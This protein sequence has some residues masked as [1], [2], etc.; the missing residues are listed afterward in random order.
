MCTEEPVS[1]PLLSSELV[2][3]AG[4]LPAS[5]GFQITMFWVFGC[6]STS[7]GACH[8]LRAQRCA[9]E[10]QPLFT[11]ETTVTRSGA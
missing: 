3:S 6:F 2:T 1:G 4:K 7:L 9:S 10:S 11:A 5:E 8:L